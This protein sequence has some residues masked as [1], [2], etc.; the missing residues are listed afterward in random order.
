MHTAPAAPR[1][2]VL[3]LLAS[4]EHSNQVRAKAVQEA[5]NETTPS[6]L[7]LCC[8]PKI[9]GGRDHGRDREQ[10]FAA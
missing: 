5:Q 1:I 10:G 9:L 7:A 6:T 4:A 2:L 3:D 8:S